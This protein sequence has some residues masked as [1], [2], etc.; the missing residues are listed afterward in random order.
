MNVLDSPG[1]VVGRNRLVR[2]SWNGLVLIGSA[3]SRISHNAL[4]RNG[5]NGSEVNGAS[6]S[7]VVVANRARGNAQFGI[8]VGSAHVSAS[9]ATPR[10]RTRPA[11]CS[12][13]STTA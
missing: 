7:V 10:R 5:N 3:G 12:S 4:D 6:D 11:S 2:N 13:T 1:S 9:S 8:V